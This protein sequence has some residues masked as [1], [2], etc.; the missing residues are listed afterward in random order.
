VKPTTLAGAAALAS[1]LVSITDDIGDVE[2]TEQALAA[3]A[4]MLGEMA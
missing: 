1:Y 3:I 4:R 2:K